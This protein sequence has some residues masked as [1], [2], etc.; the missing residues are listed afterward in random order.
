MDSSQGQNLRTF[1]TNL[2]KTATSASESSTEDDEDDGINPT[3]EFE[4]PLSKGPRLLKYD[5]QI[6]HNWCKARQIGHVILGIP[7]GDGLEGTLLNDIIV[8]LRSVSA[9]DV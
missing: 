1:L 8:L 5:L 9:V 2:I 3:D 4:E 6:L 7:D